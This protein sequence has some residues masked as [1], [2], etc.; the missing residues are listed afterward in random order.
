[1]MKTL[2]DI[3]A[4]RDPNDINACYIGGVYGCP[5]GYE[6]LYEYLSEYELDVNCPDG[7]FGD[8]N[9]CWNREVDTNES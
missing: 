8:C 2:K 3:V 4:E 6:Y 7:Y 5:F 1:M 9:K